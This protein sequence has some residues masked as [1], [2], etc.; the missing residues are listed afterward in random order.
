MSSQARLQ[1]TLKATGLLTAALLFVLLFA[2]DCGTLS[3]ARSIA[4]RLDQAD[5]ERLEAVVA[6][7][8][9]QAL[10]PQ[11]VLADGRRG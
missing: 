9:T 4:L 6:E 7:K 2:H 11:A 1:R 10:Q 5:Q 3:T 8:A